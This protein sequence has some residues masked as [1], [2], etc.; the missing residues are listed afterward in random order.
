MLTLE[1]LKLQNMF[2]L[3][4]IDVRI[5]LDAL[6]NKQLAIDASTKVVYL[7]AE[8]GSKRPDEDAIDGDPE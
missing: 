1:F 6:D 3:W 8:K 5:A 2:V 7:S 4:L